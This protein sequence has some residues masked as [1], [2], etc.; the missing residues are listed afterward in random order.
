MVASIYNIFY[1]WYGRQIFWI[2]IENLVWCTCMITLHLIVLF[3]AE[4]EYIRK[5]LHIHDNTK[6]MATI[7]EDAGPDEDNQDTMKQALRVAKKIQEEGIGES[8]LRIKGL[9][10]EQR[11]VAMKAVFNKLLSAE[12]PDNPQKVGKESKFKFKHGLNA[13]YKTHHPQTKSIMQDYQEVAGDTLGM[14]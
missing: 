14:T 5:I 8:R 7:E 11:V 10:A 4:R 3:R 2:D 9:T 13:N 1:T 6:V 12:D